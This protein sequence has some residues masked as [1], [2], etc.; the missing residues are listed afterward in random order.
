MRIRIRILVVIL[1][2]IR[3]LPFTLMW[4]HADSDPLTCYLLKNLLDRSMSWPFELALSFYVSITFLRILLELV[5]G[6]AGWA[7][8]QRTHLPGQHPLPHLPAATQDLLPQWNRS[9]WH[10]GLQGNLAIFFYPSWRVI[11]IFKRTAK[12]FFQCFG[13]RFAEFFLPG[14]ALLFPIRTWS[15]SG[16]R[17]YWKKGEHLQF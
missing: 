12:W 11:S 1:M 6:C 2:R 14:P 16:S 17:F 15:I 4:I 13:S 3:I 5:G 8:E 10:R 7:G 9:A